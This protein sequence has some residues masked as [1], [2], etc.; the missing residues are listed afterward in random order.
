MTRS[1][2]GHNHILKSQIAWG[3]QAATKSLIINHKWTRMDTNVH[4]SPLNT[5][6]KRNASQTGRQHAR[7]SM[8]KQDVDCEG[9]QT[10]P[11]ARRF[12]TLRAS[13]NNVMRKLEVHGLSVQA[14]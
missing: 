10:A 14:L 7:D 5:R 2:Q 1:D 11:S 12:V 9:T 8:M 4:F 13:E 3:D 6:K